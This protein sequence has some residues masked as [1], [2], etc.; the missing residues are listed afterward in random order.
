MPL[1]FLAGADEGPERL[2]KFVAERLDDTSRATI[3]RWIAEQRV[4]LNG[5]AARPRDRVHGGDV[6]EVEPGPAPPSR[7]EPDPSVVIDALFED[8]EVIVVNKPAGLVV[9][10][11]R[12]H[13]SGTLVNGLLAHTRFSSDASDP[14]DAEGASR[15]GIVH[16]IDKETSGVLVVAK[17]GRSREHLKQQLAEHSMERVYL[18]LTEGCPQTQ[19]LDTLHARH[20]RA[21][22][23]FTSRTDRGRRAVTTIR[24]QERL[25]HGAA[26]LVECRLETGRTHQIRVHLAERAGTPILADSLYG[27]APRSPL[28]QRVTRDLKRHALHAQVL[29]FDHPT[30]GDRLRFEVPLPEDMQQVL[31]EMR[32]LSRQ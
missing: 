15:P 25:L 4:T 13:R 8:D 26:A 10:P 30:R 16:R 5:R 27:H 14:L 19:R 17:T 2:D 31:D 18:A 20:P 32:R 12:G 11:G 22:L 3:Q 29:G 9:H 1:R 28:V 6:V 21:R 7:A 23:K 24:V